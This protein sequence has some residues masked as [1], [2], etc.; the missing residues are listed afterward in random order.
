MSDDRDRTL[1]RGMAARWATTLLTIALLATPT[2]L[3]AL[4]GSGNISDNVDLAT[5]RGSLDASE[6][7]TDGDPV[8]ASLAF[9][10]NNGGSN[11][12]TF[13]RYG[14]AVTPY[15]GGTSTDTAITLR[16][17]THQVAD[18]LWFKQ[19]VVAGSGATTTSEYF[20]PLI[21]AN[22]GVSAT[23]TWSSGGNACTAWT[24]TPAIGFSATAAGTFA[25]SY[26]SAASPLDDTPDG[27]TYHY[28]LDTTNSQ[29][30][31][32]ET[33][34]YDSATK[35]D[36]YTSDS[37]AGILKAYQYEFILSGTTEGN[38]YCL[39][40]YTGSGTSA[41]PNLVQCQKLPYSTSGSS[42]VN[43][44]P[45]FD[46][47]AAFPS[48]NQGGVSESLTYA[49]SGTQWNPFSYTTTNSA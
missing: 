46:P 34:S 32:G 39:T 1:R 5:A 22:D 12:D 27:A 45:L 31:I 18:L 37:L 35:L 4:S 49:L 8:A 24:G 26:H 19:Q 6:L 21:L 23:S 43:M 25:F 44:Y 7:T 13:I 11:V 3:S 30:Y 17:V 40:G 9:S 36:K 14:W 38:L 41:T 16:G 33:A 47:P 20:S 42:T 2:A 10:L 48:A 15:Y 28:C 29:A